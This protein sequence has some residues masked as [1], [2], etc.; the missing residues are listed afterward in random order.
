MTS[1]ERWQPSMK[2]T[3]FA[4]YLN[5]FLTDYLVNTR[6]SSVQTI[7][8]YRYT[9]IYLLEYYLDKKNIPADKVTLAD[10]DYDS[11]IEFYKWLESERKNSVATRNQRQ[12]AF[13]SFI[14][15]LMYER[16]EYLSEFQRLLGIPLKKTV[17]HEISYLKTEGVK[18][19]IEQIPINQHNGLRDYVM[20]MLLYTTGIRVS[21]LIQIKVKDVSLTPPSTLLVHGKGKKSRFV[22]LLSDTLPIINRYMKSM[23]YNQTAD[24]DEWL[25]LNH[26]NEKFTRQGVCYII[27]KYAD[28]ARKEHPDL[29]PPDMSPHKMRHTAAMELVSSGVDLIYIRDILGHV[30]VSTTEIY[31]KAD[32]KLKRAAI[33]AASKE[34]VP[35]Q[36]AKWEEDSSL[37][38]W[39]MTICKPGR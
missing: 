19:L 24:I 30:S 15:F 29:I 27:R 11:I 18:A 25:F 17:T 22:P 39:L 4:I 35:A 10:I 3:D 8:S 26:M 37:K 7:D 36:D 1:S 12:S 34:L 33:E 31:A 2:K 23:H 38:E 32:S 9:F 16:P 21:E 20:L 14:K 28:K 5:K 6:G 13:N